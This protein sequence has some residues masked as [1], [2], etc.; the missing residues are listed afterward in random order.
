MLKL[1]LT[2]PIALPSFMHQPGFITHLERVEAA[3]EEGVGAE[4]HGPGGQEAVPELG[5]GRGRRDPVLLQLRQLGR[6]HLYIWMTDDAR[7]HCVC[8]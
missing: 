3:R 1:M 7:F 6:H 4:A 8:V 2:R 5:V